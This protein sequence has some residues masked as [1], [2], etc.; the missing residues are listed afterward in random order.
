MENDKRS[1]LVILIIILPILILLVNKKRSQLAWGIFVSSEQYLWKSQSIAHSLEE[2]RK[3]FCSEHVRADSRE[4]SHPVLTI[5]DLF[6][7]EITFLDVGAHYGVLSLSAAFCYVPKHVVISIEPVK[8]NFEMILER[9]N[10]M[11]SD[12]LANGQLYVANMALSNQTK[13]SKM[14]VPM[15]RSDNAALSEAAS[16]ANIIRKKTKEHEVYVQRGD[17]FLERYTASPRLVKI[18]VQGSEIRVLQGLEKFLTSSSDV[19]L[20]AEQDQNLMQKSGFHPLVVHDYMR[21]LNFSAYCNPKV[22]L[23]KGKR[24]LIEEEEYSSQSILQNVCNDITYW[25]R[26]E[27]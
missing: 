14:Y 3:K 23:T 13:T 6:D 11:G 2:E 26:G 24:F 8:Q 7:G 10:S 5:L 25:K 20:I 9:V 17:E 15:R 4:Q 27:P 12:V 1:H 19:M 21:V 18:D 22:S 16:T